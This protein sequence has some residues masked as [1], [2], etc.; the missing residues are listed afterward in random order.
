VEPVADPFR[1]GVS[2]IFSALTAPMNAERQLLERAYA[3]F[4][5]RDIDAALAAMD[6]N[7]VWPNGMEGRYV[8]GHGAVRED[9]L[10]QWRL[11][12]PHVE[13][14]AFAVDATGRVIVDVHQV[15]RDL[16]GVV[17]N[18]QMVQHAYTIE[19]GHIKRMEIMVSQGEL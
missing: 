17:V 13:P 14:V 16:E 6:A 9:W 7:V 11:I 10:R 2:Q 3:A 5:A 1:W 12:D 8:Y 4:N 18:E 15:V 19:D